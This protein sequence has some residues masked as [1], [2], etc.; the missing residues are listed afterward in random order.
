MNTSPQDSFNHYMRT[1]QPGD[2][3]VSQQL[4]FT[5][6]KRKG[7]ALFFVTEDE[8]SWSKSTPGNPYYWDSKNERLVNYKGKT[9]VWCLCKMLF[10]RQGGTSPS[11]I[12]HHGISSHPPF[13]PTDLSDIYGDL[14]DHVLAIK[15]IASDPIQQD[16]LEQMLAI[17]RL[18]NVSDDEQTAALLLLAAWE[19]NSSTASW[20]NSHGLRNIPMGENSDMTTHKMADLCLH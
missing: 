9:P 6:E 20:L 10:V 13:T 8:N 18:L 4:K 3:I 5:L 19:I 2:C 14:Y 12:A 11:N 7:D 17:L 16:P 15:K 1:I